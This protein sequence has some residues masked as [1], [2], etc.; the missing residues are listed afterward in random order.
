[1]PSKSRIALDAA[2]YIRHL[3]K[4]G[5]LTN[6]HALTVSL[7]RRLVDQLD[8]CTSAAQFGVISREIRSTMDQ[9]PKPVAQPLRDAA[10]DFMDELE[11]L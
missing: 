8:E 1:M 10:S 11:K 9:L 6:E 2:K 4:E 7:L 5:L 3:R